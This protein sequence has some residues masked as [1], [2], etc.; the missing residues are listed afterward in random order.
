MD[1]EL[2]PDFVHGFLRADV[3]TENRR[4]ILF[5]G[6]NQLNLI[7]KAKRL[8][9]DGTFRVVKKPFVQLVTI[10]SFIKQ[11]STIKQVPLAFIFMTGK[12][13]KDYKLAFGDLLLPESGV[14]DAIVMDYQA[15]IWNCVRKVFPDI[16]IKGCAYH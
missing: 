3:S 5:T 12:S 15:A 14:P 16:N 10:H 1:F 2:D 8:F 7:Q 4:M 11:K 6:D 13:K 9:C